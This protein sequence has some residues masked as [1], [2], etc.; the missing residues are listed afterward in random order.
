MSIDSPADEPAGGDPHSV[1][2]DP[3]FLLERLGF[4]GPRPTQEYV[5]C[6]PEVRQLLAL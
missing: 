6:R 1:P 5:A 3:R 4:S 2:V